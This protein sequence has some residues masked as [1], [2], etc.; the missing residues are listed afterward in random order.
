LVRHVGDGDVS[1][2]RARLVALAER[3]SK[4]AR[5]RSAWRRNPAT[6]CHRSRLASRWSAFFAGAYSG[7]KLSDPFGDW[8]VDQGVPS[9]A[10]GILCLRHRR[11]VDQL[12]LADIGELV[13][14]QIAL[15]NPERIA[16]MVARSMVVL[17]TIAA[18]LV[19]LLEGSSHL[20]LR[21]IAFARSLRV[22]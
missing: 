15:S 14:K 3:G 10:A 22:R 12:L 5:T 11:R 6:S 8:L 13:P 16:A 9:S 18:P 4:G 19:Y 1:S 2:R 20:L 17:G 7:A 21:L